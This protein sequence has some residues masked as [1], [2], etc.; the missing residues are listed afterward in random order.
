MTRKKSRIKI[1]IKIIP[2]AKFNHDE[3]NLYTFLLRLCRS[4]V[5]LVE[6]KNVTN[7]DVR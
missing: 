7:S 2:V 6:D 1:M 3:T 5:L 4:K